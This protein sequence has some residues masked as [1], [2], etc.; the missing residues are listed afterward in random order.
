MPK[1]Q[2]AFPVVRGGTNS[3]R[4]DKTMKIQLGSIG[5]VRRHHTYVADLAA[6]PSRFRRVY[7]YFIFTVN[8][9]PDP[10]VDAIYA[11]SCALDTRFRSCK[12]DRNA[13][14]PHVYCPQV[15]GVGNA[16]LA[17]GAAWQERRL[18]AKRNMFEATTWLSNEGEHYQTLTPSKR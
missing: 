4:E 5:L 12:F 17:L 8:L 10:A 3:N 14:S 9:D 13:D 15:C 1:S 11:R 16:N 6:W 2:I 18:K 7:M